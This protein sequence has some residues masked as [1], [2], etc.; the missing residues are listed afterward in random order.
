MFNKKIFLSLVFISALV[1]PLKTLAVCPV[2]TVAV[3][4]GVGL[5]RWLGISDLISGTWIGGLIVSMS[6][7]LLSWLDKKNIRFK[8][9]RILVVVLFY[10]L[11]IAPLY[12]MGIMGHPN[13]KM[14]GMD[15]LLFGII[16]G[17]IVFVLAM[18][19]DK[20]LRSKNQQ[21][22]F[23]PFQRVVVP[24]VFLAI[25]SLIFYFTC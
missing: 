22:S 19:F 25:T 4:G 14:W 16:A 2:C 7:W 20:F 5:C 9:R 23:F 18:A 17:S 21:K 8:F 24:L 11:I 1:L 6:A 12:W 13:N 3:A 15:K 10:F